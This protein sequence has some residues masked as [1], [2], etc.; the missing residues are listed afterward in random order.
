[1]LRVNLTSYCEERAKILRLIFKFKTVR[2]VRE[3]PDSMSKIEIQKEQ[4][5]ETDALV[6][7]IVKTSKLGD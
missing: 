6:E 7:D 2:S 4:L 1:M 5:N 3:D